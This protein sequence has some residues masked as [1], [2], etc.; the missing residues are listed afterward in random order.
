MIPVNFL[1][2]DFFSARIDTSKALA[3]IIS[4]ATSAPSVVAVPAATRI[5]ELAK[6]GTIASLRS[7]G[8]RGT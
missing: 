1:A 6:L 2:R 8:R 4:A 7:S 3:V 5:V